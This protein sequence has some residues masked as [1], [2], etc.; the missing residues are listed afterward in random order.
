MQ[1]Q[2]NG[3]L[4]EVGFTEGQLVKKGDFLA[5]VDPKCRKPNMRASL[6]RT[7]DLT[8]AGAGRSGA[9]SEIGRADFDRAPENRR[10]S[11]YIVQQY[12][13]TVKLDQAQID[14]QKLNV[15]YCHIVSPVTGVS[16]FGWLIRGITCRPHHIWGS[17][18]SP[19]C[20]R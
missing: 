4:M 6:R 3:Q 12:E 8:R 20:S 19:K 11:D 14:Q 15:I 10:G 2:I 16:G 7:Q 1:T 13:G 17:R 9:L 5:Q 18:S